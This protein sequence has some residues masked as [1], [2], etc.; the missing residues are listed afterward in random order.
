MN[1]HKGM[2]EGQRERWR[3]EGSCP[4]WVAMEGLRVEMTGKGVER[5]VPAE[6]GGEKDPGQR[7]LKKPTEVL[8]REA[9]SQG[10][11]EG[12]LG[13]H[14]GVGPHPVP[15]VLVSTHNFWFSELFVERLGRNKLQRGLLPQSP[16]RDSTVLGPCA[17]FQRGGGHR[18]ALPSQR[19][20]AATCG[21]GGYCWAPARHRTPH[22]RNHPARAPTVPRWGG[23]G[24]GTDAQASPGACCSTSAV[25]AQRHRLGVLRTS[26]KPAPDPHQRSSRARSPVS[27]AA[28]QTGGGTVTGGA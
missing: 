14:T 26:L 13:T 19:G 23:P 15:P 20:E 2:R 17:P 25:I 22:L 21:G 12:P 1:E 28:I 10:L 6:H 3:R 7:E 11:T 24:S 18:G 4:A 16:P 27:R 5:S 8:R 9:Q